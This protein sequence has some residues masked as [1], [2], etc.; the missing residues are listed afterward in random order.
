MSYKKDE[1]AMYMGMARDLR[2][3]PVRIL[4]VN[5]NR[6]GLD[7]YNISFLNETDNKIHKRSHLTG[8]DQ[9]ISISYLKK[10]DLSLDK[11]L[12]EQPNRQLN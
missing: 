1:I 4:K 6:E 7:S 3:K 10:L 12:K 11:F 9:C 8:I 5:K 2:G